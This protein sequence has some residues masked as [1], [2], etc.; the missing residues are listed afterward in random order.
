MKN[1][2]IVLDRDGVIFAGTPRGVYLLKVEDI[3]IVQGIVELMERAKK[4]GYKI[5]VATNQAAVA[6]GFLSIEELKRMH[7]YMDTATNNCI[8]KVYICIHGKDDGCECRKPRPGMLLQAA[9]EFDL[10]IA[11]SFF[12][13]D[14][15]TDIQ[16]GRA[17]GFTTIFVD[18]EFNA[19]E[20]DECNPHH[21]VDSISSIVAILGI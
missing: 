9:Q 7:E 12:I 11:N 20:G 4:A 13:G 10:D 1:K 8:D 15:K 18:N 16:A 19:G 3:K 21:R 2:A 17:G 6:R 5:L 14:S